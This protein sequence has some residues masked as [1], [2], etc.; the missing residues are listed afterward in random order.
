VEVG[1]N[2]L[3]HLLEESRIRHADHVVRILLLEVLILLRCSVAQL[4]VWTISV[5]FKFDS[6]AEA[7][8]RCVVGLI[9]VFGVTQQRHEQFGQKHVAE[10]RD[11]L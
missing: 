9:C 11:V 3:L 5:I 10:L 6:I 8:A 1:E 2:R 7:D 4:E